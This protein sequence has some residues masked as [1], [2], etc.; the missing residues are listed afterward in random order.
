ME[1]FEM[2]DLL[3]GAV[4]HKDY[5]HIAMNRAAMM[6]NWCCHPEAIECD[7]SYM[8]YRKFGQ[9]DAIIDCEP[10]EGTD[11]VC[12]FIIKPEELNCEW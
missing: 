11:L 6:Y 3:N 12:I 8:F 9:Y 10:I 2:Q 5:A 4:Y 1:A 7:S